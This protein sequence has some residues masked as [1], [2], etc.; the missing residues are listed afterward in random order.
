MS[1]KAKT[2]KYLKFL[3]YVIAVVLINLAGITLFF[4]ADLTA[5]NI[6]SISD[7]SREVV[8][9]LSEPLTINVFFTRNL[10]A[11][12]NNTERY[13]R[14]LLEE[15][16]TY[17]NRHFNYRFYNVSPDQG[18]L[19]GDIR[20]NQ[21]LAQ[22]Y[23][24]EPIQIQ[25]IEEDEVKFQRA[26]MGMVLIHG[27][28]IERI[29][30]IPSTERLEYQITTAIM[31]LNNKISAL[32]RLPENIR[33]KLILSSSLNQVAPYIG[34]N[35]LPELPAEV[36]R[37]VAALKPKHFGK[38]DFV[39]LDPSTDEAAAAEVAEKDYEILS[40]RWPDLPEQN[41]AAGEGSVG[42]VIEQGQRH[43]TM[44]LV[45]VVRLPLIGTRY[46]LVDFAEIGNLLTENIESLIDINEDLGY[47]A[48]KGTLPLRPARPTAPE[49]E[50]EE[51]LNNFRTAV[52]NNYSIKEVQ[53][54]D[55]PVPSSLKTL[56]I[57]RPTEKFSEYELLQ[58]DQHL[59]RG[60]NLAL[61]LDS[62]YEIF[63]S[64]QQM[65]MGMRGPRYEPI[66]SGLEALLE[67]YGIRIRQ[68][69][70]LDENCYEQEMPANMGGG[71]R[72]I[73]FAP[74]IENRNIN[75]SL[76]FMKN[77]KRLV[78]L[79][80]S[81]LE[82]IDERIRENGLKVRQVM[83]SSD[84]SWEMRGRINLNPAFISPPAADDMQR[85][86]LAYLVEGK[87]QSY[88]KGRPLPEKTPAESDAS[89]AEGGEDG[90]GGTDAGEPKLETEAIQLPSEVESE[91]AFLA[92]GKPAK[93]FILPSSAMLSDNVMDAEGRTINTVFILNALDALNDRVEI[94][95]MRA[96]K[97]QLN[98]LEPAGAGTKTLVKTVNIAGLPVLVALFGV[99]VWV[100]R[101]SRKRQIQ[102]LFVQDRN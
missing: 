81:P 77:I 79:K 96:K 72:S 55:G 84:K 91:G 49:Q 51:A 34:L 90:N 64:R 2:G 94:A 21:Q 66:D 80:I 6:Y 18:D 33:V 48:D 62:F 63:P 14:D 12:H 40:L 46:E 75:H 26:Y 24:I 53:L 92:E 25:V 82:T 15:Y 76:P 74:L 27:D 71:E 23:G 9:T 73:Y 97:Q 95:V 20:E 38:L 1:A 17:A 85:F 86:P 16:A 65:A 83:S 7:A 98:P 3:I 13:L 10:P 11:P 22:N 70:V 5:D 36:E 67:H 41:V 30:T 42:L 100:R 57:A 56:V 68:S 19:S 29:P 54:E 101:I 50:P 89:E 39:R 59:M 61:F 88:F 44:E 52:T 69:Y 35:Q 78:A 28:M 58:I 4:R 32:L 43:T 37:T 99:G 60:N 47:L 102:A 45:Q 93:L 87:F 31:K 8:A